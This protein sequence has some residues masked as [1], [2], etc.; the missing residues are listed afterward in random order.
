M[1]SYSESFGIAIAEAMFFGL[2][3]ITTTKTPWSVIKSKNLGWFV[4]P[5]KHA[6][7]SALQ[8]LFKSSENNL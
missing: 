7:E 6:L 1:P 3:I 5:E 2:P 4:N 8:N